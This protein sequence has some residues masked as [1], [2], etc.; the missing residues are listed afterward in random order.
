MKCT[1]DPRF[2]VYGLYLGVNVLILARAFF[3]SYY[4]L[5][6]LS[7]LCMP[8]KIKIKWH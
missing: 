1:T 5:F 7:S 4:I 8:A 6:E 3:Y 2:G